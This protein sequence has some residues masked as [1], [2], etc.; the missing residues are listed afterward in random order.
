MD[1]L[2]DTRAAAYD[3]WYDT[4]E[5]GAVFAAERDCLRSLSGGPFD[6]WV[7]VGVGT[8]R[9]AQALGIPFGVDPSPAMLRIAAGRGVRAFL[10][11]AEHLPCEAESFDGAL[12][13]LTLC[14]VDDAPRAFRE[15]HRILRPAGRLLIGI[16]PADSVWG[17]EYRQKAA[18]GHPVYARARFR[19]AAET[20]ALAQSAGFVLRRT[21]GTLF[22][23]PGAS[24]GQA[25]EIRFGCGAEAGFIGMLFQK[26][27]EGG[28]GMI[29]LR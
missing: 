9:F 2:F 13:A 8:G 10:G 18:C 24:A 16:V 1:G 26:P 5:G 23:S 3:A 20:V 28:A 22:W 21:A 14:F 29:P 19:T 6:G 15:C 17:C 4:P 7:E 11:R 25:P 27:E 12:A